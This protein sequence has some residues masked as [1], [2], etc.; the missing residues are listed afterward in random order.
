MLIV[1][2]IG[3]GVLILTIGIYAFFGGWKRAWQDFDFSFESSL[4]TYSGDS[5]G[6]CL[7]MLLFWR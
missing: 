7:F 6:G 4:K 2:A 1:C 3:Y 5:G